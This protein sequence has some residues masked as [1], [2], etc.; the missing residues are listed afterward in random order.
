[1]G[2]S[3]NGKGGNAKTRNVADERKEKV[4]IESFLDNVMFARTVQNCVPPVAIHA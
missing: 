4:F 2:A 3:D 1:M